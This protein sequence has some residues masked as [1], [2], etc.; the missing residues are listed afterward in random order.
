METFKPTS[1]GQASTGNDTLDEALAIDLATLN[2]KVGTKVIAGQA[3]A[4]YHEPFGD[5]L[6]RNCSTDAELVIQPTAL[7]SL[8]GSASLQ[9]FQDMTRP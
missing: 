5:V 6:Y 8:A 2:V 4:S 3:A 7:T 1:R 9:E